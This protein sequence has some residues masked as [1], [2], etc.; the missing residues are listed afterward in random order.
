MTNKA[1]F[2]GKNFESLIK[3]LPDEDGVY[4]ILG[5]KEGKRIPVSMCRVK[6]KRFERRKDGLRKRF[7]KPVVFNGLKVDRK[8]H[9]EKMMVQNGFDKILVEWEE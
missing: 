1:I 6:S 5:I 3:K 9:L 2:N 7:S 8:N 4:F